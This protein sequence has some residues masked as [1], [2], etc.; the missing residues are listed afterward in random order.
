MRLS[1]RDI[2]QRISTGAFILH[3][4][5]EK[6]RA[7]EERATAIH[8]MAVNA[9]PFLADVSP[10]TFVKGLAL[11]EIG[12]GAALLTPFVPDKLAGGPSPRSPP[13]CWRCTCARLR[14]TSPAAC[15]RHT[16]ASASARTCGCSASA[17]AWPPS[18]R[19][20][21]AG[22]ASAAPDGE[23]DLQGVGGA[24]AGARADRLD[25]RRAEPAREGAEALGQLEAGEAGADAEVRSPAE[26]DVGVG[27]G[28]VDDEGV[29]VL[30]AVRVAVGGVEGQQDAPALGHVRGR[31]ARRAPRRGG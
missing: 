13:P 28:A 31:R 18:E 29:G 16:R 4:G 9:F 5:L 21:S 8:A 2:P 1:L 11:A 24:E 19:P 10:T 30:E 15:G 23:A 3:S 20:P 25:G 26:G 14:S 17:S 22:R 7:D 6:R 12:V 27:V